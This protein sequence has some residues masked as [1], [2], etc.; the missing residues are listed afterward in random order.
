LVFAGVILCLSDIVPQT[1]MASGFRP[2]APPKE[3]APG[4]SRGR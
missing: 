1:R 2:K 3:K 4:R